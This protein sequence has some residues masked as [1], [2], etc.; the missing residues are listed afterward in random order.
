MK[1]FSLQS[2][3]NLS[4]DLAEVPACLKDIFLFHRRQVLVHVGI[5]L[6]LLGFLKYKHFINN[7]NLITEPGLEVLY[8]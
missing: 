4:L 7:N 3:D 2:I 1:V 6:Q 5:A 8:I